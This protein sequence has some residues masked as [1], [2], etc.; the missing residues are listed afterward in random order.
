LEK[1]F[2]FLKSSELTIDN[3]DLVGKIREKLWFESLRKW[4]SNKFINYFYFVSLAGR[5]PTKWCNNKSINYV[6]FV[7]IDGRKNEC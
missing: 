2:D 3:L 5:S 4:C 7:S 1:N 6:Y